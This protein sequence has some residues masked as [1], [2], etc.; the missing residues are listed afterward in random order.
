[1]R[2]KVDECKPLHDGAFMGGGGEQLGVQICCM[3]VI[4]VWTCTTS[5]LVF[6]GL[7]MA[8][9]LRVSAEAGAYHSFTF[10]LKLELS[11][12]PA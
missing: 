1:M 10:Q 8:K 4:A 7:K 3:L 11:L 5:G 6:F 2:R 9:V 12:C